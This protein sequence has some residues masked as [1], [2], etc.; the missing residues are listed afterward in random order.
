MLHTLTALIAFSFITAKSTSVL[1]FDM[2][3]Q[4]WYISDNRF[5]QSLGESLHWS[6]VFE[7]RGNRTSDFGRTFHGARKKRARGL[8]SFAFCFFLLSLL[9]IFWLPSSLSFHQFSLICKLSVHLRCVLLLC[10]VLCCVV[11]C[12]ASLRCKLWIH[13]LFFALLCKLITDIHADA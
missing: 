13:M 5:V 12:C 2:L 1:L 11:M 9:P 7:M 4:C 10:V 8:L 6:R 3:L